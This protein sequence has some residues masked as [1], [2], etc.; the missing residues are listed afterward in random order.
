M[1]SAV[2]RVW[3]QGSASP[4]LRARIARILHDADP[5]ASG[6]DGN[7]GSGSSGRALLIPSIRPATA[8][9][10]ARQR[11]IGYA[12]AASILLFAGLLTWGPYSQ[13]HQ[14][15]NELAD[16]DFPETT[17]KDMVARHDT[18]L[19][20]PDHHLVAGVAANDF[21]AIGG[22][23]SEQ[24]KIPVISTALKGWTFAGAGPC[25][26]WGHPT[27]HLLYRNGEKTLSVF[28]IPA[29]D[30]AL[31][32]SSGEYATR[33]GD[34]A[35]AGFLKDDGLYCVVEQSSAPSTEE[36][37]RQLRDQLQDAFSKIS[38]T[39][40]AAVRSADHTGFALT[41]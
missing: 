27:A 32:Y 38:F 10:P 18:C 9:S 11:Y 8:G 41:H 14:S 22:K 5:K 13:V 24:L 39:K 6:A 3:G 15:S 31:A 7:S 20:A 40:T 21:T 25:P 26:I 29:R 30:L 34:H 2:K 36:E 17:A 12:I 4:Q 35:L 28:S 19:T 37:A 1:K 33:F 23:L 16:R